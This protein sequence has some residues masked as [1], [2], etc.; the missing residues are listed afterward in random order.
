M[1]F[2]NTFQPLHYHAPSLDTR[3]RPA[4]HYKKL[5]SLLSLS[6]LRLPHPCRTNA[7]SVYFGVDEI[8]RLKFRRSV[9]RQ[10]RRLPRPDPSLCS[11]NTTA[12]HLIANHRPRLI[13]ILLT[14]DNRNSMSS[15]RRVWL[16]GAGL[17]TRIRWATSFI[18]E[19][20]DRSARV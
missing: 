17:F 3:S 14:P 4:L 12:Q 16:P 8:R 2:R 1:T 10:Q 9:H 6:T 18:L 19:W 11:H 13:F 5:C 15:N 7:R 20:F